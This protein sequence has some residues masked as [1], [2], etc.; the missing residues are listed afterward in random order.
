MYCC[1]PYFTGEETGLEGVSDLAKMSGLL[2]GRVRAETGKLAPASLPPVWTV[3]GD[4]TCM[5]LL[6]HCTSF[7]HPG[8][9]SS[10]NREMFPLEASSSPTSQ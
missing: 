9:L 6:G 8:T 1:T 7:P 10:I 5:L 4:A 3:K 2:V